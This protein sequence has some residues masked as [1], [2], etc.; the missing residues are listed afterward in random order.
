[1][2]TS[3]LV[4]LSMTIAVSVLSA[5]AQSPVDN[6]S[7][8]LLQQLNLPG[9]SSQEIRVDQFRLPQN[10]G[11]ARLVGKQEALDSMQART[12]YTMR[13]I[14]V[15]RDDPES[16]ATTVTGYSTCEPA[17]RFQVKSAV[18]PEIVTLP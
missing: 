4:V 13:N 12:C 10:D 2:L 1:M 11:P 3:R 9:D 6:D 5:A 16:D 15:R 17:S 8:S 14:R 7:A 18:Q